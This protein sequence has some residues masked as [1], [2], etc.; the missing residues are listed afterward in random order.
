ML[1]YTLW[2]PSSLKFGEI[3][4]EDILRLLTARSEQSFSL[5]QINVNILA[6]MGSVDFQLTGI[7]SRSGHEMVECPSRGSK[8][9]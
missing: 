4:V 6:I 9:E 3:G 5:T 7:Y 1:Q 8:N 2:D